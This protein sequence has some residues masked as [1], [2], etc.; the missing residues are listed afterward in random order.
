MS[1]CCSI[2]FE[3]DPIR[4]AALYYFLRCLGVAAEVR[5]DLKV[6]AEASVIEHSSNSPGDWAE[7]GMLLTQQQQWEG[8]AH[9]FSQVACGSHGFICTAGCELMDLCSADC[10]LTAHGLIALISYVCW[11]V[12]VT[13]ADAMLQLCLMCAGW[14]CARV[15]ISE[16]HHEQLALPG[17]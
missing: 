11:L 17:L 7:R 6:A 2:I 4:R 8:A 10:K 3:S 16:H 15:C 1:V 12:I 13:A 5:I 9:C 14:A